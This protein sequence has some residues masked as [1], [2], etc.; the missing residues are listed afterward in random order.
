MEFRLDTWARPMVGLLTAGGRTATSTPQP[1]IWIG[2]AATWFIWM[3]DADLATALGRRGAP[4]S[5][6]TRCS[7][8]PRAMTASVTS[9]PRTRPSSRVFLSGPEPGEVPGQIDRP[10]RCNYGALRPRLDPHGQRCAGGVMGL[11]LGR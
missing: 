7:F 9:T 4:A 10:T 11:A 6:L 5:G 1:A 2:T 8:W 3:R